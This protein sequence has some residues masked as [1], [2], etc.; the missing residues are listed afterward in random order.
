[1]SKITLSLRACALKWRGS[2]PVPPPVIPSERSE[3]RDLPCSFTFQLRSVR[4]SFDSLRSL[5]MTAWVEGWGL[6]G[7]SGGLPRQCAHWLAMTANLG[8]TPPNTNLP[9]HFVRRA[10]TFCLLR[11]RNHTGFFAETKAGRFH[12]GL[13]FLSLKC[14]KKCRNKA[15]F[16]SAWWRLAGSNR[17]P[18]ACE[19]CALTS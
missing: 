7:K 2:P 14:N 4:R 6:G 18:H 1:M 16:V 13:F 11:N 19:A 5:R 15:N 3:S 10:F 17:R 12:S 8:C 9:L